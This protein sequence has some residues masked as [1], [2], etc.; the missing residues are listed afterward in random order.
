MHQ[1][2]RGG[3][4]GKE[5]YQYSVASD[6]FGKFFQFLAGGRRIAHCKAHAN[7]VNFTSFPFIDL[8]FVAAYDKR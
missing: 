3:L 1:Q 7:A 4:L 6:L 5:N 8:I 2:Q